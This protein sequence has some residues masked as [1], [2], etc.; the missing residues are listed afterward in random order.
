MRTLNL[1]KV[2]LWYVYPE[3]YEDEIDNEGFYT[4]EKIKIFSS[5]VVIFINIYPVSGDIS[6]QIFGKDYSCDMLGV[7]NELDLD[8]FGLLFLT[9]PTGNY[10]KT[11]DYRIDKKLPSLNTFQYGFKKRT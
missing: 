1:N 2:K 7:S 9:E 5:P 3:S 8:E 4:G 6:E 10:E 11:Y